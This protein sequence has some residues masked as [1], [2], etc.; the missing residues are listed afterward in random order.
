LQVVQTVPRPNHPPHD[1]LSL[2]ELLGL[3]LAPLSFGDYRKSYDHNAT[4]YSVLSGYWVAPQARSILHNNEI[5][6]L[7]MDTPFRVMR[8]YYTAI[9][10]AVSH[11]VGIPV[12]ISF[13]PRESIEL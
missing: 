7:I 13:G 6:G 3:N 10:V 2:P 11:N 12:A 4:N 5:D 9:L 1:F 8:H